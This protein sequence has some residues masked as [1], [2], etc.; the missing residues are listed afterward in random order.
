MYQH[1]TDTSKSHQVFFKSFHS[2]I[3]KKLIRNFLI[4]ENNQDTASRGIGMETF[5]YI[6]VVTATFDCYC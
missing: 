3:L 4:H 1:A 2:A 5:L 6:D